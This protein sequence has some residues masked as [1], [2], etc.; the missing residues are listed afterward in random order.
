MNPSRVRSLPS[1][2][3]AH[4]PWMKHVHPHDAFADLL[5]F[6]IRDTSSFTVGCSCLAFREFIQ[7]TLNPRA[8]RTWTGLV[9]TDGI[10]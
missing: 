4:G 2:R 1:P 6:V 3:S 5:P 10:S 9:K 8:S 7:P